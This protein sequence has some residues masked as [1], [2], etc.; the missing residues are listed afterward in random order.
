MVK[1]Q[2]KPSPAVVKAFIEAGF[3][4]RDLL[5]IVLAVAVKTLSNFS[6]HAFAT[7]VDERFAA[8]KVA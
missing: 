4:E 8:Y 2:G 6:N 7:E 3:Q 1:T 5:Y